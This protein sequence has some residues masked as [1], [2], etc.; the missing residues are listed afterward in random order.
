[1]TYFNPLSPCGER[2]PH[3]GRRLTCC[4]FQSTL[5]MRGETC[6]VVSITEIT[7]VISIHSPH[8]RRDFVG[9]HP[10]DLI[11]ISIHSPHAGR[12][13]YVISNDE[14]FQI[15]IHSPH[16]GRDQKALSFFCIWRHFNPLSP[17]GERLAVSKLKALN[18]DI[19][20]HSPHAGRD[21]FRMPVKSTFLI[22]IHSPHAGRDHDSPG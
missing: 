12:D 13:A 18:L 6:I 1:M 8:A 2:P 5:P 22:S 9:I 19:S 7:A 3:Q 11:H 21:S 16:A 17:C 15:S 14:V 10:E 20:I 4:I